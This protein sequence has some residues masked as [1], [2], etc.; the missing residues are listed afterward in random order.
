M[1]M[2]DYLKNLREGVDVRQSLIGLK[3]DIRRNKTG[4]TL[5]QTLAGDFSVLTAFLESSDPKVRKNAALIIAE[6]EYE[7]MREVLWEAYRKEKTLFVRADY[8]KALSHFDCTR[9]LDELYARM[10]E[11]DELEESSENQKH[12]FGEQTA[13]KT[14][15]RKTEKK[16]KHRFIAQDGRFEI[17]LLTNRE[18]RDVTLAQIPDAVNVRMLAGGIRFVTEKLSDVLPIRTYSELLFAIPGIGLLG[19][20]PGNIAAQLVPPVMKFL[21][22]C[23]EEGGPF[24]FRLDIKS[25]LPEPQRVDLVKKLAHSLEKESGGELLNAPGG[26][27]IELRLVVNKTGRFAPLLKLYT[28]HDWRFAYRQ[29]TLPTSISPVNAA[30]VMEL[31]GEYFK[32]DARVL[33]PFCGTGTMLIERRM[34]KKAG[35][36]YGVDILESAVQKAR[37]NTEAAR[38]KAYYV[39]RDFFDFTHEIP[40]DEIVTNLP[41]VGS[42]RDRADILALYDRFLCRIPRVARPGVLVA[43]YA[44]DYAPLRECL[45]RHAEYQILGEHCINEREGSFAVIFRLKQES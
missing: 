15:L 38:V 24:Y 14:V 19:G 40:F 28:I 16:G 13:L 44:Q 31:A 5:A 21:R 33:D 3:E 18:H 35:A 4:K 32:E 17:I 6:T 41:A 37:V 36:M 1:L 22:T 45:N 30:L 34:K 10:H 39:N 11:L 26:Y 8:L 12:Y 9:Y 42:T 25:S 43:A 20:S 23:H 29:E 7:P 27:E 2:N